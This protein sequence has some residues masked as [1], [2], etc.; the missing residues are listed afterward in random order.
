MRDYH[1]CEHALRKKI[2]NHVLLEFAQALLSIDRSLKMR[3]LYD[4]LIGREQMRSRLLLSERCC[5]QIRHFMTTLGH[6]I[7]GDLLIFC[8][9]G[10][11]LS[12]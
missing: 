11:L 9:F 1:L 3:S 4:I 10:L 5:Q 6:R 12:S 8:G 2:I 7:S